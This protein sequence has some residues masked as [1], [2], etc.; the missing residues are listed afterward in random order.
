HRVRGGHKAELLYVGT[1]KDAGCANAERHRKAVTT[2]PLF[3]IL[4]FGCAVFLWVCSFIRL[5]V[6]HE[7]RKSRFGF[8]D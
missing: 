5:A 2:L 6:T 4:H 7:Q 8:K 3:A 1:Q